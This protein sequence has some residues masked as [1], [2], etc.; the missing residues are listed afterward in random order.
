MRNKYIITC[1]LSCF[2]YDG[3]YNNFKILGIYENED[4]VKKQL[5]IFA[6]KVIAEA[7][8]QE[9]EENH[10][11]MEFELPDYKKNGK[12]ARKFYS[13]PNIHNKVIRSVL[14][15]IVREDM[16]DYG[17]KYYSLEIVE[18]PCDVEVKADLFNLDECKFEIEE[19]FKKDKL[20]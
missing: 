5:N 1:W 14:R 9:S 15:G 7:I 6:D 20:I 3:L 10:Y 4:D 19:W 12:I 8:E 16:P 13:Q 11:Y 18:V 17:K 2:D